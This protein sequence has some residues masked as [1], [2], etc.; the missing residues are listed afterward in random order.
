[1]D[2]KNK[3]YTNFIVKLESISDG[4]VWKIY[5]KSLVYQIE[6]L[7]F[8]KKLIN[9]G[10]IKWLQNFWEGWFRQVFVFLWYVWIFF[11]VIWVVVSVFDLLDNLWSWLYLIIHLVQAL[12]SFFSIL[13]WVWMIKFKRRYSF[14]VLFQWVLR[15]FLIIFTYFIFST[16]YYAKMMW[17]WS[18]VNLVINICFFLLIFIVIFAL[19]LRNKKLFS[20]AKK[21]V[22]DSM[23]KTKNEL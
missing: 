22:T 18:I 14:V 19:I 15:L 20:W 13:M 6:S 17:G 3:A 5:S 1:M 10:F 23:S 9:S 21:V 16:S 11:W 2:D 7:V 4:I 8:M 12:L